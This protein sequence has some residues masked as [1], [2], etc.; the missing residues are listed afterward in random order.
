MTY[1]NVL[2]AGGY[3]GHVYVCLCVYVC[4]LSMFHD[5]HQRIVC[6]WLQWASRCQWKRAAA[7]TYP[8]VTQ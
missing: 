3:S 6:W 1:T 2:C 4:V 5:I 8:L 7:V